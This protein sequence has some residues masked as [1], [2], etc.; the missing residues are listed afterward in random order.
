MLEC[1]P[2]NAIPLP[3]PTTLSSGPL[4]SSNKYSLTNRLYSFLPFFFSFSSP[5]F[6]QLYLPPLSFLP[7]SLLIQHQFLL[8]FHII[9]TRNYKVII[10]F[11]FSYKVIILLFL[12]LTTVTELFVLRLTTEYFFNYRVIICLFSYR[13][14]KF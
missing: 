11:T 10:F 13:V 6:F 2:G 3:L 12:H 8:Q 5:W 1:M 7:P 4:L 14:I 9:F